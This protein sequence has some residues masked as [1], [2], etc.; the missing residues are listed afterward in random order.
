MS[1]TMNS[2]VRTHAFKALEFWQKDKDGKLNYKKS[3]DIF[4]SSLTF[5]AM[6]QLDAR[7]DLKPCNECLSMEPSE[8]ANDIG[9]TMSV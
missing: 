3:V 2:D 4:A 9:Y 5:W 6:L 7:Q 1:S 8:K